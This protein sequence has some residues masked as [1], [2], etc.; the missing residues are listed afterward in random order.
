LVRAAIAAGV[1]VTP[2]PGASAL[3]SALSIAG[4]GAEQFFYAGFLPNKAGARK[5]AL[6]SLAAIPAT[7]VFYEAPHRLLDTLADM[8][9]VWGM[10]EAAVAREL[11]KLYEECVRGSLGDVVAH[12]TAHAPRGECVIVVAGSVKEAVAEVAQHARRAKREVYARALALKD[13]A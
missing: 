6:T 4:L 13:K 9:T 7:L 8:Q 5:A 12:F 11:T 10:R 3:L 1:R 2:I